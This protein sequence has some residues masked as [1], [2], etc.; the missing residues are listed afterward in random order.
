MTDKL[1]TRPEPRTA[2]S[3]PEIVV[4]D[5]V[6]KRF[7]LRKDN[8]LK[9]RLVA[10]GRGRKHREEF[11]ALRNV[12]A[13]ITAGHTVA[14]I[15]HNGSGKSTLLKVI[16]GIV[17]PTSGTVS[18]R[19]R[20]A[21]LLELGAGFHPDLTGRE[22]VYLNAS[23]MG[24]SR[25][26]TEARFDDIVAFSGI[27]DFIDTQVKFYSS[28]MYVRL[29]FAVAVHTD[30]DLLLVDEVLAVG[31]EAF[32]RK[33]LDKIRSFQ[34]E[35]RTIIL[36]THTL[37]QVIE[38]ADRAIL[39]NQGEIVF[40]GEPRDAVSQFRDILEE[41][42]VTEVDAN[43]RLTAPEREA[44]INVVSA[45][46]DGKTVGSPLERD[47]DLLIT[48][49]IDHY[50]PV[51]GWTCGVQIDNAMGQVVLGTSTPR[52]GTELPASSGPQT[53]QLRLQRPQF[54][55]GK[56]FVNV[57][58]MD[59]TGRHFADLPQATSFDVAQDPSTVGMLYAKPTFSIVD[60]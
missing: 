26:E 27:G 48:M 35:G 10:F 20:I 58:L 12:S 16:G 36:V 2:E 55:P 44:R 8:S 52:A 45:K 42:R 32:Q 54:G 39:L 28:G 21:A 43:G 9:E 5:D 33:C 15:G 14:L 23:I 11:W 4:I 40:D 25:A 49:Q 30:P 38:L 31:D 46:P 59:P 1:T 6:S 7:V 56:Y 3:S 13:T 29:A 41:R 18:R 47:D 22:N 37:S 19:G 24:L 50:Q 57:S 34:E 51:E 60:D 17:D 53:L